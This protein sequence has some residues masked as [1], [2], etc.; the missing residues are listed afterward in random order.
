MSVLGNSDSANFIFFHIPRGHALPSNDEFS[1]AFSN[2]QMK[3]YKAKG[4]FSYEL[5]AINTAFFILKNNIKEYAKKYAYVDEF[6]FVARLNAT[7]KANIFFNIQHPEIVKQYRLDQST[8]KS[9]VKM[10]GA[11]NFIKE[12]NEDF[13]NWKDIFER[14]KQINLE[15]MLAD[16][17]MENPNEAF[18]AS[19]FDDYG[20][21]ALDH[22]NQ[23]I[24]DWDKKVT[25]L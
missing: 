24:V 4:Y 19:L 12:A 20:A 15:L 8:L 13:K 18:I 17:K 7:C 9:I 2:H 14:G 25:W 22:L 5:S 23:Q 1:N 16:P 11:V 6:N 21:I 3:I 10:I